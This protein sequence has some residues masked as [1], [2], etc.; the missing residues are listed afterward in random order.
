MMNAHILYVCTHIFLIVSCSKEILAFCP[1]FFRY[2]YVGG[3]SSIQSI[4]IVT[5]FCVY[6]CEREAQEDFFRFIINSIAPWTGST[7]A[8]WLCILTS[9]VHDSVC[10]L[11]TMYIFSHHYSSIHSACHWIASFA[12]FLLFL[13]WCLLYF[14]AWN[15]L[16]FSANCNHSF[17]HRVILLCL[18]EERIPPSKWWLISLFIYDELFPLLPFLIAYF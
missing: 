13:L 16:L 14:T 1:V 3:I 6:M 10:S 11:I 8:K 12:V 2:V 5:R 17:C 7:C 9:N 4:R 15:V 18:L